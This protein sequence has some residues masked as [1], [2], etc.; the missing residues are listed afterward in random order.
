MEIHGGSG[1]VVLKTAGYTHNFE[2]YVLKRFGNTKYFIIKF[3][4]AQNFTQNAF[5]H[6]P[7]MLFQYC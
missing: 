7:I 4:Y 3:Q 2:A 1:G 5:R 6:F